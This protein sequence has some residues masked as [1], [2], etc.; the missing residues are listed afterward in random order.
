MLHLFFEQN[1]IPFDYEQYRISSII[2]TLNNAGSCY[3]KDDINVIDEGYFKF[4]VFCTKGD[5]KKAREMIQ[6]KEVYDII[7]KT[8]FKD[9]YSQIVEYNG[10]KVKTIYKNSLD[11]KS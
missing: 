10:I 1:N 9:S 11:N 4:A 8:I 5:L 6:S 3:V 2:V 7:D